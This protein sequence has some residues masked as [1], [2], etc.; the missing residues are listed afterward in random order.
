[1]FFFFFFIHE[2]LNPLI[3]IWDGFTFYK[4]K[5]YKQKFL[6]VTNSH[7]SVFDEDHLILYYMRCI[8]IYF[9]HSIDL[10]HTRTYASDS[11]GVLSSSKIGTMRLSLDIRLYLVTN[12]VNLLH[13]QV[14]FSNSSKI[15]LWWKYACEKIR[16]TLLHTEPNFAT[17]D[18]LILTLK[19]GESHEVVRTGDN[20]LPTRKIF[21]A[22]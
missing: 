13:K 18:S 12:W 9:C 7:L 1:M 14:S 5:I 19:Y 4:K 2:L 11:P 15:D 3:N 6:S 17:E 10:A 22:I 21:I 20:Y 8:C 16:Y